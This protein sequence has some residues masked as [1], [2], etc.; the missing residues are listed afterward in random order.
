M[1]CWPPTVAAIAARRSHR[2]RMHASLKI[3]RRTLPARDEPAAGLSYLFAAAG[4]ARLAGNQFDSFEL[5]ARAVAAIPASSPEFTVQDLGGLD[6]IRIS[7]RW[8]GRPA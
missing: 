1:S 2:E 7:P 8:P 6:L 5:P 3:C 4:A